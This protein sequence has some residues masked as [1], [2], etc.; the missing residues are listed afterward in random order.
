MQ[1]PRLQ[2]ELPDYL[3]SSLR[4]L[5]SLKQPLRIRLRIELIKIAVNCLATHVKLGNTVIHHE[6]SHEIFDDR[7]A[8]V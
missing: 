1:G 6:M 4:F 2:R 7:Q 5:G 3:V 8:F